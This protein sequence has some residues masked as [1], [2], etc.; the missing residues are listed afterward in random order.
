[1]ERRLRAVRRRL[2]DP[3]AARPGAAISG[4]SSYGSARWS[5]RAAGAR[6]AER[7][8]GLPVRAVSAALI[9]ATVV[10]PAADLAVGAGHRGRHAHADLKRGEPRAGGRGCPARARH[11]GRRD[12]RAADPARR[13][14][15][16]GRA[17]ARG[18]RR[19][20]P[21]H[22]RRARRAAPAVATGESVT[23]ALQR[24]LGVAADG[25]YGPITRAAVRAV[26]AVARAARRRRRR[27]ADARL[28]R[29]PHERHAR[30]GRPVRGRA[31]SVIAAAR[32]QVGKPYAW[33]GD[34]PASASTARA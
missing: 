33:G 24:V 30:R 9:A 26:P 11:P 10:V 18:R 16:P 5:G 27:A 7:R 28:A 34:G 12:L 23:M 22:A 21:D 6:V 25:E 32:A 29:P 8:T 13:A 20:R 4:A 17:R 14:R 15:V 31:A 19:D 2:G 1:M 3:G